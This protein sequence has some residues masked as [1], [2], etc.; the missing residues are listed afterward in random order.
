MMNRANREEVGLYIAEMVDALAMLTGD[1]AEVQMEDLPDAPSGASVVRVTTCV[2]SFRCTMDDE[3][4]VVDEI[5]ANGLHIGADRE[6]YASMLRFPI[7]ERAF[8]HLN[9]RLHMAGYL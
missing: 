5:D 2:G 7:I 4:I 6:Q 9:G 8:R 3:W 1:E